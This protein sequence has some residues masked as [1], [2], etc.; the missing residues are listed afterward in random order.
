MVSVTEHER[1]KKKCEKLISNS[2]TIEE[3]V[4][5]ILD[6]LKIIENKTKAI[7]KYQMKLKEQMVIKRGT[8]SM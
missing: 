6:I 3:E 7:Q 2:L 5:E 4:K 1:L 8:K